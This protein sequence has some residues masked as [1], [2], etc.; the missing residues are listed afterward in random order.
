MAADA[1]PQEQAAQAM[2][3]VRIYGAK[4]DDKHRKTL[5]FG[6]SLVINPAYR[7]VVLNG[8][9]VKLTR[10]EFDLLYFMARQNMR[11]F[12][13]E[14]LYRNVW[15]NDN[16]IG[17]TVKSAISALRKKLKPHGHEYIQNVWGIGYRFVG[18]WK[19]P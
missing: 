15:N 17:A 16:E 9:I 1:P 11:V 6:T 19:T 14:Q 4:D 10:R 2:A 12:T 5:A 8:E 3:L 13:P 7:M 18:K